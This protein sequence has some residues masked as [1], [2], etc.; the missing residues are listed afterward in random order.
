MN[1]AISTNLSYSDVINTI[2]AV[3]KQYKNEFTTTDSFSGFFD[4]LDMN[5]SAYTTSRRTK[6][7]LCRAL[8]LFGIV[9]NGSVV[10]IPRHVNKQAEK[11]LSCS[12]VISSNVLDRLHAYFGDTIE[13]RTKKFLSL[14]PEEYKEAITNCSSEIRGCKKIKCIN[15]KINSEDKPKKKTIETIE[16]SDEKHP[17]EDTS[18]TDFCISPSITSENIIL[19]L[20]KQLQEST[21]I[22]ANQR[23]DIGTYHI[24][25]ER[26]YEAAKEIAKSIGLKSETWK[27]NKKFSNISST[28]VLHVSDWHIGEVDNVDGFNKYNYNVAEQRVKLLTEK[29]LSWIETQRHAYNIEELVIIATGDMISGDIH[30]ELSRTN[31]FSVPEQICRAA[32]LFTKMV[33]ELARE[34]KKI[35]VE[36]IVIDNH[37]RTTKKMQFGDGRNYENYTIGTMISKILESNEK[38]IVNVYPE[39]EHIINVENLKYLIMHGNSIRGGSNGIPLAAIQKRVSSEAFVRMNKDQSHWFNKIIMGHYHVP[40]R[41]NFCEMSGCLSGTTAF[42]QSAGR[43]CKACQTGW[44]VSKGHE[45]VYAEFELS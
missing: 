34:F 9:S 28:A 24:N 18:I 11:V 3:L 12:N 22:I 7:R 37:S 16:Y 5:V 36:Y 30:D 43:Y 1:K 10:T 45:V 40:L 31:E 13:K 38:I 14:T 29:Y 27:S 2:G 15:N 41:N 21:R 17:I 32:S 19:A 6:N 25:A 4:E 44:L 26:I 33:N 8:E 23:A 20:R 39:I 35:R 42:D